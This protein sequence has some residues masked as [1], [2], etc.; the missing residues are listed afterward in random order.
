MGPTAVLLFDNF[1][2]LTIR[3]KSSPHSP[4]RKHDKPPVM[5][6]QTKI[7]EIFNIFLGYGKYFESKNCSDAHAVTHC[8]CTRLQASLFHMLLGMNAWPA[9]K[10]F[11]NGLSS[12]S[13]VTWHSVFPSTKTGRQ[14]NSF[15]SVL[16]NGGMLC[17]ISLQWD[18]FRR[19]IFFRQIFNVVK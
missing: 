6:I 12:G 13:K 7:D 17:A 10:P 16:T 1:N 8:Y 4:P 14:K 3:V 2:A 15:F 9:L 5:I 11:A 18:H 19:W